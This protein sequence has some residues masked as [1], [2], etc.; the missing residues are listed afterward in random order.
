M[1]EWKCQDSL[2][3][4]SVDYARYISSNMPHVQA[5]GTLGGILLY[6]P[7]CCIRSFVTRNR[8]AC[9][10]MTDSLARVE[11][12]PADQI[13]AIGA[14]VCKWRSLNI[15]LGK[16]S[17]MLSPQSYRRTRWSQHIDGPQTSTSTCPSYIPAALQEEQIAAG[18]HS[19]CRLRVCELL[20]SV[21]NIMHNVGWVNLVG[22]QQNG[23]KGS[24]RS[25]GKRRHP[26]CP[27]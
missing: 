20:R 19:K 26:I 13:F 15:S 11:P 5:S 4:P 18:L 12:V 24:M 2:Q 21:V 9:C 16:G 8:S 27:S 10:L 3:V 14:D 7:S 1:S 22:W 17:A 6:L 23:L 25:L